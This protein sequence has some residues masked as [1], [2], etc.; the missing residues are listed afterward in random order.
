MNRKFSPL[1]KQVISN[2]RKE[3]ID[4]GND[5][6]GVEHIVLGIFREKDS[7][8]VEVFESLD[9]DP[10]EIKD[11]LY[12]L[13]P[14]KGKV[15]AK[16]N[17]GNLPLNKQAEKVL[18]FSFL[19]AKSMDSLVVEPEHLILSI[20]KDKENTASALF[21]R[22]DVNYETYKTELD[23]LN[24]IENPVKEQITMT[25]NDPYEEEDEPRYKRRGSS[26]SRT[27]VLDNFGQDITKLAIENRLTPFIDNKKYLDQISI[28]LSRRRGSNPVLIGAP[29]IYPRNII[30]SLAMSIVDRKINR[31]FFNYRI[32]EFDQDALISGTD[33]SQQI[34]KRVVAIKNELEKNND[35]VLYIN[36]IQ[37]VLGVDRNNNFHAGANVL[38]KAIAMGHIR[39]ICSATPDAYRSF[40]ERQPGMDKS[41]QMV[42]INEPSLDETLA[43]LDKLKPKYEE[44]HSVSFSDE[45]IKICLELSDLYIRDQYLPDKVID[46]LDEVGARVHL[47]NAHVPKHIEELEKRIE[48]LKETKNQAV[49]N[50]QYE[51]AAD[52]RDDESK[53]VRQ[54][55]FAKVEWE[56]ETKHKRFPIEEADIYELFQNLTGLNEDDL[57][58]R[59]PL[60]EIP[61]EQTTVDDDFIAYEENRGSNFYKE[62]VQEYD[63]ENKASIKLENVPEHL[64][65]SLQQYIL[66]FRDY[67]KKVKGQ[68]IFFD[69]TK[70]DDGL[71]LNIKP[72]E[73]HDFEQLNSWLNEYLDYISKTTE[74]FAVNFETEINEQEAQVVMAE[75]KNQ[76]RFMESQIE[77]LQ[78]QMKNLPEDEKLIKKISVNISENQK[79]LIEQGYGD[80]SVFKHQLRAHISKGDI[81]KVLEELLKYANAHKEMPAEIQKEILLFNS[82]LSDLDM[83]SRT[84]T[85]TLDEER[86]EKQR[87]LG[88]LIDFI[89]QL[90]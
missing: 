82:R 71:R 21:K 67:L 64:L 79:Q 89:D 59:V 5:Y 17:L 50:Q 28:L 76:I 22:F 6:I 56:E 35:V 53:L 86:K 11:F 60:A 9:I 20:L 77:I 87:I 51:K 45:S 66:Y 19:E 7:L 36:D 12:E 26:R 1:V 14:E 55:E 8:A 33:N 44:F 49:K 62:K 18:K 69:V 13:I 3:A 24:P 54:L 30:D 39:V 81:K 70:V 47:K 15:E 4:L 52:L 84:G 31:R 27:P 74:E 29:G 43:I 38:K 48:A 40:I 63:L 58:N 78:L 65:T 2:S 10:F 37:S 41:F 34:I 68:E 90:N 25:P 61:N 72:D 23:Y 80:Q 57:Q 42:I 85:I 75:I 46:V 83:K 73:V 16:L 32:V 88:S